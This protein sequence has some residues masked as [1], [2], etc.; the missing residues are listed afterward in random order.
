MT[1]TLRTP[2][3]RAGRLWLQHRLAVAR[4][5]A[6]LLEHKLRALHAERQRLALREERSR[7]AW[8]DASREAGTW[9]L[10]GALLGGER[11]VRLAA[12]P[13]TADVE[14]TWETAV[15]VRYPTGGTVRLPE[16]PTG[17]APAASAALVAARDAYR[18]ALVAAVEQAA[19][20]AAVRTV[21]AQES[22]TRRRLRAVERR[23]LPRLEDRLA[24]VQLQLDE[25]EHADGVRLRW[26]AARQTT[27]EESR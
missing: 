7:V 17:A 14:V 20:E 2:P 8:Q 12:A 5:G 26:S 1:G 13:A 6:D 21:A 3:G 4:Q 11:A 23:W 19:V 22:A 10:R 9:L 15:G 27:R 25:D 24:R 16:P 18:R